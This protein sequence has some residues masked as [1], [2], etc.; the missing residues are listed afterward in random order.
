M[1]V[2]VIGSV[3][4]DTTI[5]VKQ[6]PHEGETLFGDCRHIGG[7]GK[8]ANQA[9]ALARS[10]TDTTFLFAIGD[11]QNGQ[12]IMSELEKESMNLFPIMKKGSETGN[13]TIMVNHDSE[14]EIIVI[15]G[16]NALIDESDIDSHINLIKEADYILLQN[17]ISMKTNE[18]IIQTAHKLHKKIIYNPAPIVDISSG[19]LSL[20]DYF[21]PNETELSGYATS[22]DTL[23][24][25]CHSLLNEGVKNMIVTLGT[26]GSFYIN[27]NESFYTSA[28]KVKAVDTV[29][30]GDTYIGYFLASIARDMSIKESMD[31]ASQAS[32]YAVTKKGAFP[33]I[34]HLSDIKK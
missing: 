34:P 31:I 23:E 7:G 2:L 9:I 16:A 11:D 24:E 8:G 25:K 29:A 10:G 17:E 33:S 5:Y 28:Y 3:N 12:F 18:Y 20:V 27:S 13:A 14:N 26:S 6:F 1:K 4:V 32:A 19:A 21:I 30:A 22:G 15:K